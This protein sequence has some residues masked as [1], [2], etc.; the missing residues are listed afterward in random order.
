MITIHI[1]GSL[2]EVND[3]EFRSDRTCRELDRRF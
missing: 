1:V 3:D 2:E